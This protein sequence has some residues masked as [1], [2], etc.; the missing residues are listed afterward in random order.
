MTGFRDKQP[1]KGFDYSLENKPDGRLDQAI[2]QYCL[3][4][5]TNDVTRAKK[6]CWYP[7]MMISRRVYVYF[8][9]MGEAQLRNGQDRKT[10]TRNYH[11]CDRKPNLIGFQISIT[12][13]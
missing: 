13:S 6:N 2:T 7:L 5:F 1:G 10:E 8:P 11:G 3:E 12:K 9:P 4:I